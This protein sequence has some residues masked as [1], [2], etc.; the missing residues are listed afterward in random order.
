VDEAPIIDFELAEIEQQ[1]S[2]SRDDDDAVEIDK[3]SE[4]VALPPPAREFDLALHTPHYARAMLVHQRYQA[5]VSAANQALRPP[6][7]LGPFGAGSAIQSAIETQVQHAIALDMLDKI[8]GSMTAYLQ[9]GAPKPEQPTIRLPTT[10]NGEIADAAVLARQMANSDVGKAVVRCNARSA[11]SRMHTT[12]MMTA[13]ADLSRLTP[14]AIRD[15]REYASDS[16]LIA[17][18]AISFLHPTTLADWSTVIRATMH[19]PAAY[20]VAGGDEVCCNICYEEPPQTNDNSNTGYYTINRSCIAHAVCRDDVSK[21]CR[22][23][24]LLC[25]SCAADQ[26]RK[27]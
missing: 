19:K 6:P 13:L 14:D 5:Y 2:E 17:E 1:S 7:G 23:S 12:R 10:K 8:A 20:E 11:M 4:P 9:S 3:P 18:Q 24:L 15:I 27:H 16:M 22:C 25:L 21:R 26:C